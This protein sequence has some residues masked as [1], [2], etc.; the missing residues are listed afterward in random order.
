MTLLNEIY[1]LK[2]Y[3]TPLLE[4]YFSD[5]ILELNTVHIIN[6][7]HDFEYLLPVYLQNNLND[8][9]LKRWL[10]MCGLQKKSGK[11]LPRNGV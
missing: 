8:L 9:S 1:I 2:N 4:F 5:K 6:V 7:Y 3:D 11:S 10:R